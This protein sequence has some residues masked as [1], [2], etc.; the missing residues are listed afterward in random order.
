MN[1]PNTITVIRMLLVPLLT[2]LLLSGRFG[3][4]IGVFLVA[5]MGDALDGYLAR[6]LNQCTRLGA[7]LDPMADKLLVVVSVCVLAY[8]EE[9]PWWLVGTILFRD[10]GILLG[11]AIIYLKFGQPGL[12]P[13]RLSKANTFVQLT[14]I[15][16]VLLHGAGIL[17]SMLPQRIFLILAAVTTVTSGAHYLLLWFGKIRS[18]RCPLP[19]D[20]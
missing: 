1:V 11:A 20:H 5:G 18:L 9:I 6:K 4:A 7:A 3:E 2:F 14:L 13:S 10:T 16:L 12:D 17:A 15:F 8:H 19:T